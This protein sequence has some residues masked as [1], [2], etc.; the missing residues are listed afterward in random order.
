MYNHYINDLIFAVRFNNYIISVIRNDDALVFKHVMFENHCKWFADWLNNKRYICNNK[1]NCFLY[2]LYEYS[3]ELD[4][5][6]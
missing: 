5:H 2:F 1:Y 6:N 4:S 3:I